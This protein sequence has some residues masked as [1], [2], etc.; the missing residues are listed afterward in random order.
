M[1]Y[2]K[3]VSLV[4]T[5]WTLPQLYIRTWKRK[6]LTWIDFN[7]TATYCF[8]V[9]NV[10]FKR[11]VKKLVL[12]KMTIHYEDVVQRDINSCLVRRGII[13]VIES[14]G[15]PG[16]STVKIK[17][18]ENQSHLH[19]AESLNRRMPQVLIYSTGKTNGSVCCKSPGR[20]N[21][22]NPLGNKHNVKLYWSWNTGSSCQPN[23]ANIKT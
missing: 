5:A 23:H 7:T 6:P 20:R 2:K 11:L 4:D 14:S 10:I 13:Q 3:A 16:H 12:D 15:F 18:T 1:E 19:T 22:L 8:F 17:Q 21:S 9:W